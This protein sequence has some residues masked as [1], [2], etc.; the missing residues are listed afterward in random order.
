MED[1]RPKRRNRREARRERE[2]QFRCMRKNN[3]SR[4]QKRTTTRTF[5]LVHCYRV[6]EQ[7]LLLLILLNSLVRFF[8]RRSLSLSPS[9]FICAQMVN[10][11]PWYGNRSSVQRQQTSQSSSKS[12]THRLT[13]LLCRCTEMK[14]DTY[15]HILYSV[16]ANTVPSKTRRPRQF[17]YTS[18]EVHE[19]I[20]VCTMC[21]VQYV[22]RQRNRCGML[23]MDFLK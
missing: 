3:S 10:T 6:N 5:C 16:T 15:T 22:L 11:Q 7:L 18:Y 9:L 17:Y 14:M 8:R 23:D 1:K 19:I 2:K 20:G 4:I 21:I 13:L 12:N